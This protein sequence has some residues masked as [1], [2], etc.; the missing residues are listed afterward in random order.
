MQATKAT[1]LITTAGCCACRTTNVT[2]CV[3]T[4]GAESLLHCG[5]PQARGLT[6]AKQTASATLQVPHCKCQTCI[7]H[8]AS[9]KHANTRANRPAS[10]TINC[11]A[12]LTQQ[13]APL[14]PWIPNVRIL[15]SSTHVLQRVQAF[16]A[17]STSST[18]VHSHAFIHSSRSASPAL[19]AECRLPAVTA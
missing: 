2:V 14:Q 4:L 16:C 7:C 15:A 10:T 12:T 8:T 17:L 18:A 9:A 13:T 11:C 19:T 3:T 6:Q 1:N 5:I